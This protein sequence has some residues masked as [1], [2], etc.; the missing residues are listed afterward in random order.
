MEIRSLTYHHNKRMPYFI[1]YIISSL[2][3][4]IE[5]LVNVPYFL[6]SKPKCKKKTTSTIHP[7][8]VSLGYCS[9]TLIPTITS[10]LKYITS[11][12]SIRGQRVANAFLSWHLTSK[13]HSKKQW[14]GRESTTYADIIKEKHKKPKTCALLRRPSQKFCFQRHTTKN[15]ASFKIKSSDFDPKC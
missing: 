12:M 14:L 3:K 5:H 4:N 9:G 1:F 15:D 7:G 11:V 13:R 10:K 6:R 2:C 8:K